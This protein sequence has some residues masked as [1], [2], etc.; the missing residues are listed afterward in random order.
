MQQQKTK[1]KEGGKEGKEARERDKNPKEYL[2][3]TKLKKK[4]R[5]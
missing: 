1:R 3:S 4:E 2:Y 5:Y